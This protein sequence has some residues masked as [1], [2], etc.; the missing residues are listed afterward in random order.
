MDRLPISVRPDNRLSRSTP[1]APPSDTSIHGTLD[2]VK[3]LVS[4][5]D[6]RFQEIA[7]ISDVISGLAKHSNLLALNA[8]IEAARVGEQGRGFAV[9]ADEVRRLSERTAAATTDISAKITTIQ[10]ESERAVNG[11]EEAEKSSIL[12]MAALQVASD[13]AKLERRF[14]RMAES[15]HGIKFMIQ[16]IKSRGFTPRRE[17]VGAMMAES[18][19]HNTDV[20]AFSCGCEPQAFDGCDQN[21]VSTPGH[22][23]SGRYVPY[24]HRGNGDIELEALTN[25]DQPGLNDFYELPRK[26]RADILMEPYEYPVGGKT[27]LM[28]SLMSPIV[29]RGQFIGVVGADYGLE[30]LQQE[31]AQLHP[32]G[33][34]AVILIS[35]LGIYVTHPEVDKLGTRATDLPAAALEAIKQG[36]EH[37]YVDEKGVARVFQPLQIGGAASAWSM[38]VVFDPLKVLGKAA[39]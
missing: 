1:V 33:V 14:A 16:G 25:Y 35:N 4:Q 18:L 39:A 8:A 37:R 31:F 22:D 21:Y 6:K 15:L 10:S 5:L 36:R 17:D 27:V 19:Q 34:G 24:W 11:V 7:S 29:V 20:L 13:A 32:F 9:V 12:Q 26:S 38:V 2:Q 3:Q 23:A 28:T 30:Q